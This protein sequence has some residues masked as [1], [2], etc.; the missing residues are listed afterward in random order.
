MTGMTVFG[1]AVLA[2]I[3]FVIGA[4]NNGVKLRNYVKE[5]FTG[6]P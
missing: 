6:N 4:Y 3:M 5:A 2:I 1:V